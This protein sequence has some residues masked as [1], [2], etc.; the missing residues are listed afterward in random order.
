MHKKAARNAVKRTNAERAFDIVNTVLMVL[1]ALL[2]FY[3]IY[4]TVIASFSDPT[5]VLPAR[6]YCIPRE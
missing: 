6:F 1:V 5:S 4:F 2:C 3:P